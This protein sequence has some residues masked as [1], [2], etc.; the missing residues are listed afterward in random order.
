MDDPVARARAIAA[1]LS[2]NTESNPAGTTSHNQLNV[3]PFFF[4]FFLF[5]VW[6]LI[7]RISLAE[8]L[9][10]QDTSQVTLL[11]FCFFFSNNT[12][13]RRTFSKEVSLG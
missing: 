3:Q 10:F 1:R 11:H 5:F 8:V 2:G 13:T 9:M 7:W 4:C 6:D 12:S